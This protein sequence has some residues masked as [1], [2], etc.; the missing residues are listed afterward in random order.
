VVLFV[1]SV[2]VVLC[3]VL[4]ACQLAVMI[5]AKSPLATFSVKTLLNFSRDHTVSDSLEYA[6]TWNAAMLQTPDTT[7]A[8]VAKL[9]KQTATFPNLPDVRAKL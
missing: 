8:A 7:T 1:E 4:P 2:P 5:A 3:C 9:A 6:I